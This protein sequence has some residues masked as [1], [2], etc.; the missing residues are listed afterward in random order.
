V[1]KVL[2]VKRKLGWW[3]GAI[4]YKMKVGCIIRVKLNFNLIIMGGNGEKAGVIQDPVRTTEFGGE[5]CTDCRGPLLD[6]V[7]AGARDKAQANLAARLKAYDSQLRRNGGRD[8]GGVFGEIDA[9][10]AFVLGRAQCY[11]DCTKQ[12]E[13]D[14]ANSFAAKA[15]RR[16]RS[17]LNSFATYGAK[18]SNGDSLEEETLRDSVRSIVEDA[19]AFVYAAL[20]FGGEAYDAAKGSLIETGSSVRDTMVNG[21]ES[22]YAR[23]LWS[24]AD[25]LAMAREV[26][27]GVGLL[28]AGVISVAMSE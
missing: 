7:G 8:V 2:I 20:Y 17:L 13:L 28:V 25:N 12:G 21:S 15:R 19:E 24:P 3:G 26:A 22:P 1:V 27:E 4:V 11:E 9:A 16:T 10:L 5:F 18:S 6:A 14:R 23:K